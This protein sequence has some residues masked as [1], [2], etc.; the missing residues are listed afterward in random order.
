MKRKPRVHTIKALALST[1]VMTMAFVHNEAFGADS[2]V[3]AVGPVASKSTPAAPRRQIEEVT[4]TSEKRRTNLQKTPTAITSITAR[5]LDQQ[6]IT[7]LLDLD[8]KLPGIVIASTS[9][10]PPN[11]TIRGAGFQG[12]QNASSQPGVS[13][14][15]N[16]VYIASPY[17]F[18]SDFLDLAQIDVLRGPQGTVFGQN[19]DGGAINLTT[20]QPKLGSYTGDGDVSYGSYNYIRSRAAV[21]IPIGNTFAIRFA[22]QQE[23][24]DGWGYATN[25][26]GY[27]KYPLSDEDSTTFRVNAL[28][29]PTDR[30]SV[31]VW[32]ELYQNSSDGQEYKSIYDPNPDPRVVTQDYPGR[33]DVR[34]DIVA[35]QLAY[36]FDQATLKSI[37]SWQFTKVWQP[38]DVDKLDYADAIEQYGVHD[39]APDISRTNQAFTQEVDL[40]SNG[41]HRLDWV[42]GAFLLHQ[43]ANEGFVEYQTTS[44]TATLLSTLSPTP[45]QI[46]SMFA[47]GL[48]FETR[49]TQI[50][51]SLSGYAQGT[52]HI[53]SKLRLTG[54][55]R[56][57]RDGHSAEVSTYFAPAVHLGAST[58]P[59]T[60][61][62]ALEY[63]LMP[64]KTVYVSW[65]SGVK[66]GGTNLN[67][68]A[69]VIPTVFKQEEVKAVEV[70]SKN[71]FFGNRLRFN[72]SAYY[73]EFSNYQIESEDPVPYQG[74]ITNIAKL[75]VYGVEG[76]GSAVLPYGFRVDGNFSVADGRVDSH[77]SLLDPI[78]AQDINRE[79]GIFTPADLAARK[80]AF[81]DV[82]GKRPGQ[83]PPFTSS[84]ALSYIHA[85]NNGAS[86]TA[87]AQFDYRKAYLFRVY[88]APNTD[89]VPDLRQWN[90]FFNYTPPSRKWH[91]D[92]IVVN[93]F[94]TASIESRYGGNFGVGEITDY[95]VPPQQFI[96]R[97]G[98]QF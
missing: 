26:P 79:D 11:I 87:R 56:L 60:G 72:L 31:N 18:S 71:L 9:N 47:N 28:W 10:N 13:I 69:T 48:D 14:N 84:L 35:A 63:D 73:N 3:S 98:T 81:V 42:V 43:Q 64:G 80:A 68:T 93:A 92:F 41:R 34:S 20:I 4:V 53:T 85:F 86:V 46:N 70:G 12:T 17:A 49:D 96:A 58:R 19:S 50:R 8:S 91:F 1:S 27:A 24:H 95:Y 82:Y 32:G 39:I 90:M 55:V 54:G 23:Q 62:A 75:H 76:E 94:N 57:T 7:S 33:N 61:K 66:P 51:N 52:L 22:A 77:T 30:F 83:V 74:G 16:G 44:P 88:N 59:V 21:N 6:N 67:P 40:A 65:S 36:R 5:T 25:V 45:A 37:S 15:E 29:Q 38:E 97:I 2:A 89:L 78:V